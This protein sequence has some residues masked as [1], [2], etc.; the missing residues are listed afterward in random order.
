MKYDVPLAEENR[1]A[2]SANVSI[3]NALSLKLRSFPETG[4]KTLFIEKGY[5]YL[6][7]SCFLY[8]NSLEFLVVIF[9]CYVCR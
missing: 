1:T 6:Y 4:R 9:N 2:N 7:V 5:L 8:I 3:A